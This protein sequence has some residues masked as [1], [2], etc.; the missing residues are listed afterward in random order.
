MT[1]EVRFLVWPREN[2]RNAKKSKKF[3]LLL[4]VQAL[5]SKLIVAPHGCLNSVFE[6]LH[7]SG[8][9]LHSLLPIGPEARDVVHPRVLREE[10]SVLARDVHHRTLKVQRIVLS[11]VKAVLE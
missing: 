9:G 3:D 10:V 4:N 2:A 1:R 5:R 8:G 6:M 11:I 7:S